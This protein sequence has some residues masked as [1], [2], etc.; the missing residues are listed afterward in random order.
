M[1]PPVTNAVQGGFVVAVFV[2]GVVFGALSLIFPEITEGLG[3]LL[4]GFCLS[5]WLLALKPGGL[6][7]SSGAKGIVIAAFCV[8]IYAMSFT[9]YTRPYALIASTSFG[10]ATAIILGI[11]CF[12]RAGL[13]EFWIYLWGMLASPTD[14]LVSPRE[15]SFPSAQLGD[16]GIW[17][18]NC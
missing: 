3:C 17:L 11:D 5:M 13:K 4:G 12:A 9:H 2:T 16:F 14:V 8:G 15:A 18:T 10:G 6:L 7:I 1:N